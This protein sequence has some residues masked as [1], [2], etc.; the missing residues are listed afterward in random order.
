MVS[1]SKVSS[2]DTSISLHLCF[3]PMLCKCYPNMFLDLGSE[4]AYDMQTVHFV[5]VLVHRW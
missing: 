3:S 1:K 4:I 2:K 5:C